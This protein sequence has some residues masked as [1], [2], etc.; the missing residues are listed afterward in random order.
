MK[1]KILKIKKNKDNDS[2][3]EIDSNKDIS[4]YDSENKKL[5]FV[6]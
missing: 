5:I 2:T 4:K 1:K 3:E 6:I